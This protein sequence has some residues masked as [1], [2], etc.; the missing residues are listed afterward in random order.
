MPSPPDPR[1]PA[2]ADVRRHR[3]LTAWRGVEPGLLGDMPTRTVSDMVGKVVAQS[4][5][6]ERLKLEEVQN[7]WQEVVGD[8]LYGQSKPDTI[9]R[10]VL[11]VRVLQPA[12]H[13]ALM[14]ERPRIL[15]RLR[16]KLGQNFLKEVRFKHG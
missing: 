4:G 7:A 13:H 5:I 3:M 15:K 14:Q 1:L 12:V 6:N 9:Q 10:G 2:F 8:F 16:E 11:V